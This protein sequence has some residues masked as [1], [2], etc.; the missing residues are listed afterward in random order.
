MERKKVLIASDSFKGTLSSLEIGRI[1]KNN[2]NK[3]GYDADY[4][5][6]SDG[7]EGFLD[8]IENSLKSLK[9]IYHQAYDAFF[10]PNYASF[11]YDENKKTAYFELAEVVGLP[12]EKNKLD[13]YHA[14]TYGLGYLINYAI[15]N[16]TINNIYIGIGGSAS[17][18]GGSGLLEALGLKFYDE[19]HHLIDHLCNDK[20]A[21]IK[22]IDNQALINNIKNIKFTV[23]T[24]VTNPLLGE[25]GATYVYARQKGANDHDLIILENNLLHF[26]KMTIDYLKKDCS[27]EKGSGAAGGSGFG[28]MSYLDS[29]FTTGIDFIIEKTNLQVLINHYDMVITGEGRFDN[30]SLYGKLIA[31]IRKL[32][33]K[34]LIIICGSKEDLA[35]V[36]HKVYAIVPTITNLEES[37]KMPKEALNKL[38]DYYF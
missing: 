35:L 7:G 30:Q 9:R 29:D 12:K 3:K 31:G 4:I 32:N 19:N 6:V 2:L 14:S 38:L 21:L 37:L 36:N 8:A 13:P 26:K 34:E 11:L 1:I 17:N 16:Y 24:D 20:L 22:E 28:I 10:K 33:P 18:D 5:A 27:L 25:Q 23:L 15:H